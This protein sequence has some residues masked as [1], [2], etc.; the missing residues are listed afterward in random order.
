MDD[1]EEKFSVL[2]VTEP[3]HIFLIP[4]KLRK[5]PETRKMTLLRGHI[6]TYICG[7]N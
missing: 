2:D 7:L 4:S 5:F 3:P 1:E 6:L